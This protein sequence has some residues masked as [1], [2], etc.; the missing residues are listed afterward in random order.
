MKMNEPVAKPET[1]E[2]KLN[3]DTVSALA[4]ETIIQAAVRHGIDIP[5]LCYK[6]GMRPDGNCRACMVEIK[7]E[8]VLA[9]S[10]CRA[11]AQGMEVS[12]QSPRALHAQKLVVELLAADVPARVY[13]LDSELDYWK[14]SLEIG[15]PRFE[16][17]AQ[18]PADLSHPALAGNLDACIQCKR[19]VRACRE[20]QVN[21]VIGYA[22]RGAHSVHVFDHT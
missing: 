19:C 3:G 1:I 4:G 10:C 5:Q 7:G 16:S 12:S 6:E 20:V 14:R 13:K 15:A 11:P 8:R 22:T 18:L 2:F 17:R 21:Y 9:P